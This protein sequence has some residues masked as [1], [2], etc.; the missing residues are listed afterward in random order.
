MSTL[1]TYLF[2]LIVVTAAGTGSGSVNNPKC[3]TFSDLQEGRLY[4]ES[5][6]LQPGD[7]LLEEAGVP[8][9][10]APFVYFDGSS[11][12]NNVLA[13]TD[14]FSNWNEG[15]GLYVFPSNINL[16]FDFSGQGP[17]DQV[18]FDFFDG[19]GEVNIGVNDQPVEVYDDFPDA[20]ADI[21][22]N[23]QLAFTLD[24]NYPFPVGQICFTGA[25]YSLTVG[26]QEM[27][28]DNVCLTGMTM[29][30]MILVR[31]TIWRSIPSPVQLM[32]TFS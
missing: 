5:S 15:Q 23:V 21:A 18:C 10:L 2:S 31:S 25:I 9:S 17:V 7:L 12:F 28:M 3:I 20:P 14:I 22:P 13:T 11:D 29:M 32:V 30:T 24:P 4:G 1:I 6:G 27:A 8:V 26:G 16:V 19:G